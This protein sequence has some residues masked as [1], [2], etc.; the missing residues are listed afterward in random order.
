[1]EG[2]YLITLEVSTSK[3]IHSEL[4]YVAVVKGA[5]LCSLYYHKQRAGSGFFF[6]K[7]EVIESAYLLL[8]F[9]YY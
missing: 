9:P 5:V 8:K 1:M 2:I 3:R 7:L 4:V 6:C